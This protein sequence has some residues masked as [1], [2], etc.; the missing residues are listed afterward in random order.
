MPELQMPKKSYD[1][2]L[3]KGDCL[4]STD[5]GPLWDNGWILGLPPRSAVPWP[6]SPKTGWPMRHAWTI[7]VPEEYRVKG[8]DLVGL[9]L[10]DA[11]AEDVENDDVVGYLDEAAVMPEDPDARLLWHHAWPHP[12]RHIM[13]DE[14]GGLFAAIWL[15]A[16]EMAAPLLEMPNFSGN[17]LLLPEIRPSVVNGYHG[18][19][20]EA[21]GPHR[22]R[23]LDVSLGLRAAMPLI[24]TERPDPNAGIDPMALEDDE[25]ILAD[26]EHLSGR[27]HFGGT[28]FP[29]QAMPEIGPF[30]LEFDE[31][32]GA[33]NFGDGRGQ[34][35]LVTM[36]I[37]WAC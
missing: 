27:T 20:L 34:I 22:R 8:P 10:F 35:D 13:E 24:Y 19:L 15:T 29:L 32:F 23:G 31:F 25:D 11:D 4:P 16:A 33:M 12:R 9:S 7:R 21:L 2:E 17:R 18:C 1:I 26:L 6:V 3:G 37:D 30:Y 28:P 36:K 5:R 14:I